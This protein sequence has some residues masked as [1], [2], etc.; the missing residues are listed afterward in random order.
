MGN[1]NS[2][3][4]RSHQ[5]SGRGP[6]QGLVHGSRSGYNQQSGLEPGFRQQG[7]HQNMGVQG[8]HGGQHGARGY[9]TW[10]GREMGG[11]SYEGE[12]DSEP[13]RGQAQGMYGAQG[14]MSTRPS[15]YGGNY[16]S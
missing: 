11:G 6:H 2:Q 7:G 16:S 12:M 14:G 3:Q 13:G 5:G 1:R 8:G 15:G 9:Q 10:A 4:S